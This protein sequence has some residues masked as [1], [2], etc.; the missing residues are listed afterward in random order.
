MVLVASQPE[1]SEASLDFV[2]F[3][4]GERRS[5]YTCSFLRNRLV[6]EALVWFLRTL[7]RRSLNV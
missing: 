1:K 2:P 3:A 7:E 6:Q 4:E 5:W